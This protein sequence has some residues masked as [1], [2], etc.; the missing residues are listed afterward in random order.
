[1]AELT[2]NNFSFIKSKRDKNNFLSYHIKVGTKDYKV[3]ALRGES[4]QVIVF[5]EE[6]KKLL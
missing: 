3:I 2:F 6:P 4:G 1:V 5:S